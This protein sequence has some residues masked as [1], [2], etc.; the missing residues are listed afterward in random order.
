MSTECY[1]NFSCPPSGMIIA[2]VNTIYYNIDVT[3][4]YVVGSTKNKI[5]VSD[6]KLRKIKTPSSPEDFTGSYQ[7]K[8]RVDQVI[9]KIFVKRRD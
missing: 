9:D 7:N 1:Q 5:T 6:W 8:S 2:Q 4:I 3:G